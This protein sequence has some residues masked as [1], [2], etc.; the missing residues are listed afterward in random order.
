MM[1]KDIEFLLYKCEKI[2]EKIKKN[3]E[4]IFWLKSLF[5]TITHIG[6]GLVVFQIH[7]FTHYNWELSSIFASFYRMIIISFCVLSLTSLRLRIRKIK[8]ESWVDSRLVKIYFQDIKTTKDK[9]FKNLD[10]FEKE[11]INLRIA[12]IDL[13]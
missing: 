9:I 5:F 4:K 11:V 13:L 3:N 6:V 7:V 12:E 1:E 10:R 8:K 2:V